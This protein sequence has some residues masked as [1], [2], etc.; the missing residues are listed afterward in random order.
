MKT[1]VNFSFRL[2]S[3]VAL[4]SVLLLASCGE[5]E[6]EPL[7]E[8]VASFTF[9]PTD[10]V[11]G[12][13]ISFT[14]GSV[15]ATA[16]Q[17]SFGDGTTSTEEN[18]THTYTNEGSYQVTLSVTGEGG[19]STVTQAV[20][21]LYPQ[22]LYA[23]GLDLTIYDVTI[24]AS[25]SLSDSIAEYP[26]NDRHFPIAVDASSETIY[27]ID[28]FDG[29][30]YSA[31]L[32][33]TNQTVIND[34]AG[35]F[36]PSDIAL[37]ADGNIY[38]T[39][40][41]DSETGEGATVYRITGTGTA[42]TL[43]DDASGLEVPTALAIDPASGDLYINDVGAVNSGYAADGIWVGNIDGSAL[44]KEITGGGYSIALGSG[45]IYFNDAFVDGNIK[46]AAISDLSASQEFAT[47]D[48]G[49]CYGIEYFNGRVYWS[50]LGANVDG[51]EGSIKRATAATGGNVTV[52][53]DALADPRGLVVFK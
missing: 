49:N 37:D 15:D 45:N 32:D 29:I 42:S 10:P 52:I 19:D 23:D 1:L 26:L 53:L 35:F 51:G 20:E 46:V 24:A 16:F 18:P 2:L 14:S 39:D 11:A 5:D 9:T 43:Y 34:D 28:N 41:G 8:P 31:N 50:D 27:Y 6:E 30:L 22:M 36:Y 25:G 40:R 44:T 21:V 7:P 33:G 13:E 17:W 38:V 3:I 4:G 12:E 47:L 48:E